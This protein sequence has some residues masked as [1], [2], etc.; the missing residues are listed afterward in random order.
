MGVLNRN[1]SAA[2]LMPAAAWEASMDR[3]E[4]VELAETVRQ[5]ADEVSVKVRLEDL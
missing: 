4:D 5:R 2:C 1:M 3:L